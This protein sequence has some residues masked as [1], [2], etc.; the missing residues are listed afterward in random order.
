MMC[1]YSI[2]SVKGMKTF[3]DVNGCRPGKSKSFPKECL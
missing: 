3:K 2:I 1:V